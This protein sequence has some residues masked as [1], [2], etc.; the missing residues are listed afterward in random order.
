MP[1]CVLQNVARKRDDQGKMLLFLID[2]GVPVE[3]QAADLGASLAAGMDPQKKSNPL[4]FGQG[5]ALI[6]AV[7]DGHIENVRALLSRGANPNSFGM[8]RSAL[9]IAAQKHDLERAKLLIE[10]GADVNLKTSNGVTALRLAQG[11]R[12]RDLSKQK[13]MIDYLTERG[14]KAQ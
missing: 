10:K 4:N 8:G 7:S 11:G 2:H 13:A 9:M 6:A 5:T 1:I 3:A 14:A 12:P